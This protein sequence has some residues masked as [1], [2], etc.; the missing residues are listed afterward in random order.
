MELLQGFINYVINNVDQIISLSLDHIRLT[1]V[2]VVI[3]VVLGV[4]IGIIISYY[5]KASKPVMS[6]KCCSSYTKYGYL[7]FLFTTRIGCYL[8]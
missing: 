7:D 2:A 3:A 6:R 8:L 5:K 1:A 4:P